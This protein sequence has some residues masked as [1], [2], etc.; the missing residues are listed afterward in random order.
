MNP[1]ERFECCKADV[2][3]LEVWNW[4]LQLDCNEQRD[5]M[6]LLS[7]AKPELLTYASMTDAEFKCFSRGQ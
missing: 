5:F 1:D 2:S 4:F 6:R 7:K 3:F